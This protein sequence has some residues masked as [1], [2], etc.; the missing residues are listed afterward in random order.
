MAQNEVEKQAGRNAPAPPFREATDR[1]FRL[2]E[3]WHDHP[4]RVRRE[5]SELPVMILLGALSG[6]IMG[7]M[8][9]GYL[10]FSAVAL[11][12]SGVGAYLG[13]HVRRIDQ[14][15]RPRTTRKGRS[16]SVLLC[17]DERG[18]AGSGAKS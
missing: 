15:E 12:A 3:D 14:E 7:F 2:G 17:R 10:A 18:R 16:V 4:A 9:A 11:V 8:L 1:N 6:S 5:D 13:W